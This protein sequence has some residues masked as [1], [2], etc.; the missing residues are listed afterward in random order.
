MSLNNYFDAS[1]SIVTCSTGT[2]QNTAIGIIRISGPMEP[3]NVLSALSLSGPMEPRF[4]Y[5]T[6][7]HDSGTVLDKIVVTY[8][9][10]P[11]SF[12]GEN[13]FELAV[14][15]NQLNISKIISFLQEKLNLRLAQAG[16][17][18]YRALRNKKLSLSQVEGLDIFLNATSDLSLNSGL[19]LI[20]GE[21]QEIF[22]DLYQSYLHL[23]SC[24]ELNIDFAEDVGEQEGYELF[25]RSF[26]NL[27]NKV[28]VLKETVSL[29]PSIFTLPKIA[30]FGPPNAG[31]STLFN[32][33][34]KSERSIVSNMAGTTRDYVS[35]R[36]FLDGV[37]F[38]LIDTAGIRET[39]EE[40][41]KKGI[42]L[43][44]GKV[45]NA[46]FRILV[47][48]IE[49]KIDADFE[50][51]LEIVSHVDQFNS[52]PMEPITSGSIG[53]NLLEVDLMGEIKD[54]V[55]NKFKKETENKSIFASRHFALINSLH[56]EISDFSTLLD[57][58]DDIAIIASELNLIGK[59]VQELVGIVQTDDVLKN[60]FSN[61]CIGK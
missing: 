19:K 1:D 44:L 61:F 35:A 38:E 8:F 11:R 60:I 16:E 3:A 7:L 54:L 41:E 2:S 39:S 9:E 45:R 24:L 12:T 5:T 48:S 56:K 22:D 52:A 58:V 37:E 21:G 28:S 51:D 27:K 33:L 47:R 6:N 30:L 20:S 40:I 34:L 31:K 46:F 13:V 26:K 49:D 36:F 14:H 25:L 42:E 57:D 55:L 17:F 53:A 59:N 10:A 32:S 23:R 43:G 15:G 4:A 50:K 29:D 18:S